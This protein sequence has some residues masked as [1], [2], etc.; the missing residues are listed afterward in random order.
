MTAKRDAR[1]AEPNA[2]QKKASVSSQ[3]AN[4]R[5]ILAASASA[6][7]MIAVATIGVEILTGRWLARVADLRLAYLSM[8]LGLA[9]PLIGG[10]AG[11]DDLRYA[12]PALVLS[13][14]YWTLFV[15]Y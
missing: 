15:L 4:S 10:L 5:A 6:A 12:T 14:A 11:R 1:D 13:A 3:S 9:A 7:G 8:P 2:T